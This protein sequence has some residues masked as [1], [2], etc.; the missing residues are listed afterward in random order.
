MNRLADFPRKKI[1]VSPSLLAA[2]FGCLESQIT[3]VAA[4]GA[5]MLH[6]DV[7]DGALVPNISFGAP[8]IKALRKK[9]SL[10][11]D[12]HLMIEHPLR[13]ARMFREAGADLETF[14]IEC[15]DDIDA[16]I[17]AV[18]AL[19]ADVGIS[20]KPATPAEAIFPYLDK[21]DLVLVMTVE[22]GFGGQS[23]MADQLPKV[24]AFRREIARRKLDVRIQVAGGVDGKTVGAC[25]AAG[26]EIMVA[27]TAVFRHPQGMVAA[28]SSLKAARSA[29]DADLH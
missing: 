2:D 12:V 16:V 17:A 27:G 20:L 15:A 1:L 28:V 24:T 3:Q 5:E 8:V 13:Y 14:H 29:L 22:P 9:S 6:L 18:H 21:I 7:M 19:G 25:A 26:A 10:Y 23:F 11:F 4:A